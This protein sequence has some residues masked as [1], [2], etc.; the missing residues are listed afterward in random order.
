MPADAMA[1]S[2]HLAAT[3]LP[4]DSVG[5]LEGIASTRAIDP[6]GTSFT[7]AGPPKSR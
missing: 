3:P 6:P 2:A 5:L 1:I 4:H 7:S